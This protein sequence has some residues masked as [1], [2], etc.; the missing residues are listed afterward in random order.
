M[1]ERND[2]VST[3]PRILAGPSKC[4]GKVVRLQPSPDADGV[5]GADGDTKQKRPKPPKI[6][7]PRLNANTGLP[8][9]HVENTEALLAAYGVT[10][11]FNLMT[12]EAEFTFADGFAACGDMQRNAAEA[13]IREWANERKVYR[14]ARFVD[15]MSMIIAKNTYHPVADWIRSVPWDGVKRFGDLFDSLTIAP[16][17]LAVHEKHARRAFEAWLVTSA[18]AAMLPADAPE[19]IAAQGVLV[20]QGK[21]GKQKTRWL[22]SLTPQGRG[23]SKESVLLD[24]TDRDSKQ[25]A[26]DAWIV[27]LGE[28]D[29][30]FRK[31]DMAHLKGFLTLRTDTYRKAYAK[32]HENVARRTTFVASVNERTYLVDDTGSRRF[33]SLPVLEANPNH[34]VNL[35]QLWAEAA[36]LAETRPEL[37]WLSAEESAALADANRIFETPDPMVDDIF[38]VYDIDRGDPPMCWRNYEEIRKAIRPMGSWSR[39]ETIA[40][41]KALD[42]LEVPQSTGH[43]KARMFALKD[44]VR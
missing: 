43:E 30:T 12:H 27:E 11:R 39:G 8:Y 14:A 1:K 10:V 3:P 44:R 13:R 32:T 7:W 15:Q 16:K 25:Q 38:R 23:W 31:S 28:L 6:S 36:H 21:Q 42:R 4:G 9:S 20:L 41:G 33:W 29:G 24:P 22:M 19:G 5:G 37:G 40:L 34:G 18:K 35:Q 26:T 2:G 17:F